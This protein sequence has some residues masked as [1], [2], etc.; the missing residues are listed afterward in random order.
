MVRQRTDSHCITRCTRLLVALLAIGLTIALA[1]PRL[2]ATEE[3]PWI[4][5]MVDAEDAPLRS[6]ASAS[7]DRLWAVGDRGLVVRSID[8]G[9]SWSRVELPSVVNFHQVAFPDS[10]HGFI[11]GGFL[12]PVLGR[13]DGTIMRSDDGGET[14]KNPCLNTLGRITGMQA[15][16]KDHLMVWGDW[17]AEHRSALLESVD[18]GTTFIRKET[19][20]AQIAAAAWLDPARGVLIDR[21]SRVFVTVNGRDYRQVN[22]PANPLSPLRSACSDGTVI[23]I[24]GDHGQLYKSTDLESWQEVQLNASS[25]VQ[26]HISLRRICVNEGCVWIT[27]TYQGCC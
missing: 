14:W 19:P 1:P 7:I 9:R 2:F 5:S 8:G 16:S 24:C 10:Q 22:L 18:G 27:T 11:C 25:A 26:G 3:F 6:C 21:L 15:Y 20:C 4:Y 13:S 17:S 12:W 23:W